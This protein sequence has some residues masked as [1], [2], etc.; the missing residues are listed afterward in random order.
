MLI[1]PVKSPFSKAILIY[2]TKLSWAGG[3]KALE[4]RLQGAGAVVS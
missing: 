1:F 3:G 2:P 4:Q